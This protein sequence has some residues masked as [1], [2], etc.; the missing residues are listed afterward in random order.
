MNHTE[1]KSYDRLP[2]ETEFQWLAFKYYRD[3]GEGRTLTAARL[4]YSEQKGAKGS[5]SSRLF[6]EW[7]VTH[8]WDERVRVYDR[9]TEDRNREL[10]EA[11]I[12]DELRKGIDDY[13]NN[14]I[15]LAA[16]DLAIVQNIQKRVLTE[17]E[18]LDHKPAPLSSEDIRRLKLISDTAV[19]ATKVFENYCIQTEKAY[20]LAKILEQMAKNLE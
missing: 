17:L 10:L 12:G 18:I 8:S 9:D 6:S 19:I 4:L 15:Q 13:R 3:L 14:L 11:Q 1:T 2:A 7:R 16:A 5:G 20:H